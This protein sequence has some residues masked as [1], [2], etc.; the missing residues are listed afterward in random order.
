MAKDPIV[1]ITA[2]PIPEM[3]PWDAKEVG[4]RV[5][6]TGRSD[7][8]N[9]INNSLGFPGIFRGTLDVAA[10][11]ITDG[12]CIAAATELAKCA[13]DRGLNEDYIVP[14]MDEPNVFVREAVAVGMKAIEQGV[15]RKILTR[16]QL[17]RTA[18]LIINRARSETQLKMREKIIPAI[19][20]K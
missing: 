17:Y 12:M 18:E 10:T 14:K 1:F 2:N 16:D 20:I 11:T 15:A 7:F 3:W 19:T 13:E 9:Q 6:G 8:P 4:A 5:V